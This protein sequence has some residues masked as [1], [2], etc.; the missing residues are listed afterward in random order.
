MKPTVAVKICGITRE[1]DAQRAVELGARYVGFIFVQRSGRAIE[2][3]G[4]G[5]IIAALPK[6]VV[7]VGVFVNAPRD[8][9]LDVIDTTGIKMAQFHGYES[10]DYCESFGQFPVMKAFAVKPSFGTQDIEPYHADVFLLDTYD[11][12]RKGGTGRTF[13]WDIAKP[14][15]DKYRVMLAGGLNPA[16]VV[17]A[18]D[19]VLPYGV[20]VS[21]G[22]EA[23]PGVKDHDKMEL[24]F[25]AL[26]AGGYH[27][28]PT[29]ER[30]I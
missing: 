26:H 5:E 17:A 23:A 6:T 13:D 16:N 8:H 7:P 27:P 18:V 2:P 10:P 30:T 9:V 25:R 28:A 22:V 14:V 11:P 12:V 1:E 3:A 19:E 24:L 29:G 4:A 20:D 15:A 21:S